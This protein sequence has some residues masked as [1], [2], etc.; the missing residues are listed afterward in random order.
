MVR[1]VTVV[2]EV[3]DHYRTQGLIEIVHQVP[4]AR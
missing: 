4:G 2:R 3:T 1:E